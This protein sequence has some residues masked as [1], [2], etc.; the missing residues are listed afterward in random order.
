MEGGVFD[1]DGPGMD[2]YRGLE[3]FYH[4]CAKGAKDTRPMCVHHVVCMCVCVCVCVHHVVCVCL[5]A[6]VC[7]RVRA[8]VSRLM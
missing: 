8:S 4:A 5:H 2:V 7:V 6:C 3:Q 1:V